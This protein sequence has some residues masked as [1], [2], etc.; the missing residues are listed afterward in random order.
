MGCLPLVVI[1]F[2][3]LLFFGP[4]GAIVALLFCIAL[5]VASSK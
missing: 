3:A 4:V 2:A 5:A 1:T